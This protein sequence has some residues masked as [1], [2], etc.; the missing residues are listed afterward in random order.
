MVSLAV[1]VCATTGFFPQSEPSTET[2]NPVTNRKTLV[3]KERLV[4]IHSSRNC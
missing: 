1:P 2:P 3:G 4:Q